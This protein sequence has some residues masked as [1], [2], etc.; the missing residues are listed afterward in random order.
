M[1]KIA[2]LGAGIAGCGA[3]HR[4]RSQGVNSTI[5]EKA[6][7]PGGHTA[8]FNF[9]NGFIFDDGPHVSFTK[10]T[11]IQELFAQSVNYQYETVKYRVN[12]YWRS[13]WIKHPAHC[14][15]Y[16]LPPRL[17]LNILRD[18]IEVHK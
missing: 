8:S 10:D 3:A 11:R 18:F 5:Y 2:I 7:H 12:N 1:K 9:G 13:Y 6:A 4:L 17:V 15:L 16:G 14:N